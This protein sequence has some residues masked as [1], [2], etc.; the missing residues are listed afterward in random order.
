[1][2]R[3]MVFAMFAVLFATAHAQQERGEIRIPSGYQAHVEFSNLFYFKGGQTAFDLSTTH[4][5]CYSKNTFVGLGFGVHT[6]E[7]I[8]VGQLFAS[9]KFITAPGKQVSPTV[10]ARMGSFFNEGV[11]P[12]GELAFGIRCASARDFAFSILACASYYAPFD[13]DF[14]Y[15]DESKLVYTYTTARVNLSCVGLRFGIEW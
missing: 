7:D 10:Q 15:W 4:G 9:A 8:V 13:H 12:Y 3:M 14:D 1:M 11:H 2:K 6:K 5:A